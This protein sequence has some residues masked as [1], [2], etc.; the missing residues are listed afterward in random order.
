MLISAP[1]PPRSVVKPKTSVINSLVRAGIR[2]PTKTPMLAPATIVKI[3]ITVPIPGN[4]MQTESKTQLQQ[5][6]NR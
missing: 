1:A 4:I 6:G 5:Q 2:D 3:L